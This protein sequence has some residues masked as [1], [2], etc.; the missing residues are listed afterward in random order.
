MPMYLLFASALVLLAS[1]IFISS[2]GDAP[3]Q[4]Y[5]NIFSTQRL[6][7]I[8]VSIPLF[9]IVVRYHQFSAKKIIALIFTILAFT[10]ILVDPKSLD[11]G[12]FTEA[13]GFHTD[14]CVNIGLQFI[15]LTWAASLT[16][17]ETIK[18]LR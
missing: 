3:G 6:L 18:I 13:A 10:I 8:M 12:D 11:Y 14:V 15:L 7:I 5:Q 2:F 1:G 4:C 16:A 17:I 9:F